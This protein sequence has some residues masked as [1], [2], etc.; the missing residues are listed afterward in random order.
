[1]PFDKET[2]RQAG[3]KSSRRGVSNR[4]TKAGKRFLIDFLEGDQD[5]AEKDW[6]KLSAYERWQIRPRIY[7]YVLPKMNRTDLNLNVDQ[8][9][10]DQVDDILSRA[11]DKLEG[12]E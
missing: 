11:L 8:L 1:M 5:Q 7:E 6:G 9:T 2:A 3:K 10:D 4:V 12:N